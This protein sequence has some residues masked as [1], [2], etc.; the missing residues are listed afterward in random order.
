MRPAAEVEV[1]VQVPE[2]FQL[3]DAKG[4]IKHATR[5]TYR[6]AY[7]GMDEGKLLKL[8]NNPNNAWEVR[9]LAWEEAQSR[10]IDE[11]KINVNGSLKRKWDKAKS[12]YDLLN[13]NA[14]ADDDEVYTSV[15]NAILD[16]FDVE[17]AKAKFPE[18]DKGWMNE[19]DKRI[20][21]LFGG[22]ETKL[23]R[24]QYDAFLDMMKR[25]D[26]YYENWQEKLHDL[27]RDYLMFIKNPN[28]SVFVSTGGAGAGKSY[29]LQKVFELVEKI[30]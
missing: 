25:E 23:Q 10:G 21:A 20:Q 17:A 4:K 26:P 14:N 16:T 7:A 24:Q 13:N 3:R 19:E 27:G 6:K 11:S 1:Q 28:T 5:D 9:M 29:T 30:P 15:N 22:L 12:E 2:T 8:L 18:G